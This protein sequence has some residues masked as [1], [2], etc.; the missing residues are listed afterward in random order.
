MGED[1]IVNVLS[2]IGLPGAVCLYTLFGV[3]KSLQKQDTTLSGLTD[4]INRLTSDIDRRLD[5][6]EDET[7][8]LKSSVDE[9]QREVR[10]LQHRRE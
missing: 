6:Q 5:K 9:L 4:A 2:N 10:A 1:F 3:N 7:R 8:H